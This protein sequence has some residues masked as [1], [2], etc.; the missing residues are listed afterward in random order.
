MTIASSTVGVLLPRSRSYRQLG[1]NLLAGLELGLRRGGSPPVRLVVEEVGAGLALAEQKAR[2]LLGAEFADLVVGLLGVNLA[3]ALRPLFEAQQVCLLACEA[4]ENFPRAGELWPGLFRCSLALWQANYALGA[5]AAANLGRRAV[6]AQSFYDSGYD[7]PFAFGLGFEQAGGT[8]LQTFL[9]H[10][11]PDPGSFGPIFACAEREA[12]DLIFGSYSGRPAVEFVR[13]YGE[14]GLRGRV[15]LLGGAFLADEALLPEQGEAALGIVSA[16]GWDAEAPAARPFLAEFAAQAGRPADGFAA[17]GY[18][19]GLW[20]AAASAALGGDFGSPERVPA[21]LAGATVDGP[22]GVLRPGEAD[23]LLAPAALAVR[24][25][26]RRGDGLA[27]ETIAALPAPDPC[28]APL[29]AAAGG[30]RSGWLNP[31]LC[32]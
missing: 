5:W 3:A 19:C 25:V 21:A 30:L 22:R 29:A 18:E 20:I 8:V 12:P 17:L 28:E 23:R 13:A 10:R 26:R 6:L 7:L 11:P 16:A 27:G 9:T 14:S 31:Y 1:P 15:P 32:V 24:E 2:Q 4:G